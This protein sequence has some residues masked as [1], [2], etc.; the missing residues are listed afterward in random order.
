MKNPE[1]VAEAVDTI[2]ESLSEEVKEKIRE[3]ESDN[4]VNIVHHSMGR[5]I[6]N[7]LGLWQNDSPIKLDAVNTYGIAHADD[8]S[9]LVLSWAAARIKG[10]HFD[11]Q[12]HAQKYRD[13]WQKQGQDPL[14]AGGFKK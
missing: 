12:E 13:F 8:I 10:K 4:F 3:L 5:G 11:P 1:T 9:G 14:E 6:R 2:V 7:D